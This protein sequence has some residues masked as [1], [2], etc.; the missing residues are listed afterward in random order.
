[1][2][3]DSAIPNLQNRIDYAGADNPATE[4]TPDGW[5]SNTGHAIGQG[6][7]G[8]LASVVR[9]GYDA[10]HGFP[11]PVSYGGNPTAAMDNNPLQNFDQQ[12]Q[13]IQDWAKI[14]PRTTGS[15]AAVTGGGVKGA[16]ELGIGSA[17]AIVGGVPLLIGGAATLSASEGYGTDRELRAAGVDPTTAAEAGAVSGA[18]SAAGAFLPGGVGGTLLKKVLSGAAINATAG[19]GSRALT[20]EVLDSGGYHDMAAQYKALDAQSLAADAILGTAFGGL[21]H[22]HAP[23]GQIEAIPTPDV[24]EQALNSRQQENQARGVGGIPT[25]LNTMNLDH[26]LQQRSLVEVLQ[27]KTPDISHEEAHAIVDGTVL[28]PARIELYDDFI[29]AARE[30]YGALVDAKEPEF[31]D[32]KPEQY[33]PREPLGA[34]YDTTR[35]GIELHPALAENIQQLASRHADM[36]VEW[37]DGTTIK[38]SQIPD[39]M[40]EDMTRAAHEAQFY[41]VAVGCFLRSAG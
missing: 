3:V 34:I 9:A 5:F 10:M 29:S 28:D 35:P 26:E 20:S 6:I 15:V 12:L 39:K 11:A 31:L 41:D 17:A 25:D 14:D 30:T 27:G 33:A 38:A 1:M 16:T 19:V 37:S 4:I 8:G 22:L 40:R 2:T 7:M 21:A 32:V 23:E 24:I 13:Y 36:D 18:F